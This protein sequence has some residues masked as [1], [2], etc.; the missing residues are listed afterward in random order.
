MF[1]KLIANRFLFEELVKR[2]FKKKYKETVLGVIWSLLSPLLMLM[3]YRIVFTRFFGSSMEHYTTY[4]FSGHLVFS[5]YLEATN[6]GM[7]SLLQNASIFTKVH[8]PKYIFLLAQNVTALVNFAFTLCIFF[9][10]VAIDGVA[11]HWKFFFLLIP[12]ACLV[13]FNIGIGF[14]LS[15]LY[16]MFRDIQY[17]YG[18]LTQIILYCS[19][20]FY[21]TEQYA[22]S[23][24]ALFYFNPVF[25]FITYFRQIVLFNSVPTLQFHLIMLAHTLTAV[26]IGCVVYK[27]TNTK[28]LYYI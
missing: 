13:L 23:A 9:L 28:F 16:I 7:N 8:V 6:A 22:P 1:S 11:F 10:F 26:L 18:V 24:Q 27:K 3:V 2:D 15:A 12:I 4:L 25:V 14:I 5:F 20:I 19:A 17:L 21:T